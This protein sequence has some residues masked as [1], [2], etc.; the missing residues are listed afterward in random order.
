MSLRLL[1]LQAYRVTASVRAQGKCCGCAVLAGYCRTLREFGDTP[2]I[3]LSQGIEQVG[4]LRLNVYLTEPIHP[5]ILLVPW[6]KGNK[7][8]H[9][10]SCVLR[11]V[12]KGAELG[13]AGCKHVATA[14]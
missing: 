5:S 7:G 3:P 14:G 4:R 9:T 12:N 2:Y 11:E 1:P 10:V 13:R 8:Q 6:R